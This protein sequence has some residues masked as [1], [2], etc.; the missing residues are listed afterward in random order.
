MKERDK[1]GMQDRPAC[2]HNKDI[3]CNVGGNMQLLE[4]VKH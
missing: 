1:Q 2:Q 4:N 3:T